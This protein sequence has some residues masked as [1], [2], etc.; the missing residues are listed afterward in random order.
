[1]DSE[2]H[3]SGI[4]V[5]LGSCP[6]VYGF[7]KGFI[8]GNE[9]RKVEVV[10][11]FRLFLGEIRNTYRGSISVVAHS[12]GTYIL[13][14]YLSNAGH[15]TETFGGVVLAGSILNT[16]YDWASLLNQETINMV[17]N[18]RS[19]NDEWVKMLPDGGIPLL[20][21]DPLMGSAA[22]DGFATKHPRLSE[23]ESSL[24]THSNMFESDVMVKLWLPFLSLA[25]QL[26]PTDPYAG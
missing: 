5:R 1:M 26:T 7:E 19:K 21:S 10:E 8:L 11:E 12:F 2:V 3:I 22:V 14:R 16:D 25:E 24:L 13:G 6:V 9:S 18:T 23:R 17:M 15:L 4:N 20:A